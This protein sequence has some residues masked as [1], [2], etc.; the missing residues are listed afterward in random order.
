MFLI[1]LLN[2]NPHILIIA[3]NKTPSLILLV[4]LAWVGTLDYLYDS[5]ISHSIWGYDYILFSKFAN[6]FHVLYHWI[7]HIPSF[8]FLRQGSS[9]FFLVK[10]KLK[11]PVQKMTKTRRDYSFRQMI[12]NVATNWSGRCL[13]TTRKAWN[14][15]SV[16]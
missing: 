1:M 4:L 16:D 14:G 3:L 9:S 12:W 13:L 2:L 15:T 8:S 10:K 11:I 5:L 6:W 7:Y